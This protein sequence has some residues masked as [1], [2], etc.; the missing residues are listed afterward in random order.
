MVEQRRQ[1]ARQSV[2][3]TWTVRR[4]PQSPQKRGGSYAVAQPA[5]SAP[6]R[7]QPTQWP[8]AAPSP[9]TPAPASGDSA[10]SPAEDG[11]GTGQRTLVRAPMGMRR[12]ASICRS[13]AGERPRV[14]R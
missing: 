10:G 5:H 7:P 12:S 11:T 6:G 9:G 13:S 2:G 1:W 8:T 4:R 14:V 3:V